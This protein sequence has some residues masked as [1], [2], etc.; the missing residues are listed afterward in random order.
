MNRRNLAAPPEHLCSTR[1]A[2]LANVTDQQICCDAELWSWGYGA[3]RP[4]D[5]THSPT[6]V[7]VEV[8]LGTVRG[9]V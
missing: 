1:N 3:S 4:S 8:R 5:T 2:H 7:R 9:T 6:I